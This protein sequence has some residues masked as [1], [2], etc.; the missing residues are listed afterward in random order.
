LNDAKRT[1]DK[2]RQSPPEQDQL[3]Q[4][5]LLWGQEHTVHELE[6]LSDEVGQKS[7]A[8]IQL[9]AKQIKQAQMSKC[10]ELALSGGLGFW[11]TAGLLASWSIF[12]SYR[13]VAHK[14]QLV[15]AI[16]FQ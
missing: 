4:Q 10:L 5:I 16:K 6:R 1:L 7:E 2:W 15:L 12:R 14:D 13:V 11:A 8:L 9:E 3:L